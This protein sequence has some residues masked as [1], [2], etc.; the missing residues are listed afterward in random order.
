MA[1]DF[2]YDTAPAAI[3][4]LTTELNALLNGSGTAAGVEIDNTPNGYQTG[5]LH[6]HLLASNIAL[7]QASSLSIYF[8][9]SS[10]PNASGGIYPS[11]TSGAS[12]SVTL[13]V[14]NYLAATI[15]LNPKTQASGTV[16]EFVDGVP[17]PLGR[18][19]TVAISSAQVTF[20]VSGNTLDITPTP[21]TYG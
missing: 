6:V 11:Y 20:P 1:Q 12:G 3:S 4:L 7:T 17:I 16:D 9:P 18:Y 10:T 2:K 21:T 19:K 15:S 8:L 14:A 13:A 5:R